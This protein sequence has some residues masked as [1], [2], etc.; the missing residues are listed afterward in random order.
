M[1]EQLKNPWALTASI[2]ALAVA[3]LYAATPM[4]SLPLFGF[5]YGWEYVATFYKIG[6]YIEM[7]P[8]LMP[9][10]GLSGTVACTMTR[11]R[12]AHILS[13]SFTAL[14]LMF[15]GYFIYMIADYPQG[16][17][18]G[19]NL[20]KISMLTTIN[21]SVWACLALSLVSFAAAIAMVYSENK[22]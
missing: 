9:F 11:S 7:I 16:E 14:P 22:K 20:E 18:M 10:I 6:R 13:I 4:F 19:A 15:F 17:I 1:K 2:L 21:W 3:A 12:G 8:F 5:N